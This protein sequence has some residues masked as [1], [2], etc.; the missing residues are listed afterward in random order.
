M[1][2][3]DGDMDLISAQVEPA[4]DMKQAWQETE[5]ECSKAPRAPILGSLV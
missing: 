5:V 4:K 2:G 3:Q 1:E